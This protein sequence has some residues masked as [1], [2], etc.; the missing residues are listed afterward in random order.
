MIHDLKGTVSAHC[1]LITIRGVISK[2]DLVTS[3]EVKIVE[4]LSA[5][6]VEASKRIKIRKDGE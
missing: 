1:T 3:S 4:G 2:Y 5:Q 6:G